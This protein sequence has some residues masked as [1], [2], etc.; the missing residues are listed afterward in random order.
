[1][2]V[3]VG[4]RIWVRVLVK[5]FLMNGSDVFGNG[6]EDREAVRAREDTAV[7]RNQLFLLPYPVISPHPLKKY[8]FRKENRYIRRIFIF[9]EA[10]YLRP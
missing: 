3:F 9:L 6:S 4:S 7:A 8:H 2:L 10:I 1:M 5:V